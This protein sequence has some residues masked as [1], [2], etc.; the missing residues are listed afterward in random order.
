MKEKPNSPHKP[1]CCCN[2]L[3]SLHEKLDGILELQK[4]IL[5]KENKIMATQAEFNVILSDIDA[6]TNR[7]AAKI[8]ELVDKLAAGGMSATEEDAVKAQLSTQLD[9]LK[10]IG[11][12]PT[13]P[14]P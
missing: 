2:C 3:Q 14:V 13:N 1:H 5:Q 9:K 11:A 7:I 8:Q 10:G 12:D 6:E 4:Q